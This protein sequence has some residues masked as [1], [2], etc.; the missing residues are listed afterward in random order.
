MVNFYCRYIKAMFDKIDIYG[1]NSK[2]V[3]TFLFSAILFFILSP[4]TFFEI[5]PQSQDSKFKTVRVNSLS[6][7]A[8]HS[9]IFGAFILAFYYFYL[10]KNKT[11]GFF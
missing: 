8:I 10:N 1:Q 4:G 5:D 11:V 9:V 2:Y 7:T 6:T 3:A